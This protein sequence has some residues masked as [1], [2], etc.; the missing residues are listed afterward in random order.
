MLHGKNH[1]N[2][3]DPAAGQ[4]VEEVK[5]EESEEQQQGDSD[6]ESDCDLGDSHCDAE[7]DAFGKRAELITSRLHGRQD[8]VSR[9]MFGRAKKQGYPA[10]FSH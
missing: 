1:K 2:D 8:D 6:S 4:I 7:M 9:H 5:S 3:Q 10:V